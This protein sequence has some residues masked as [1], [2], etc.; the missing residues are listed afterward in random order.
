M[1]DSDFS[2]YGI[3]SAFYLIVFIVLYKLFKTGKLK[4][5]IESEMRRG[6]KG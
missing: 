3:I 4:K 2:G 5:A 6:L 1:L